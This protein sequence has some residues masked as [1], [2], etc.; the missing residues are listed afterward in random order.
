MNI[1]TQQDKAGLQEQEYMFPYHYIPQIRQDGVFSSIQF[2]D[3]GYDYLCCVKHIAQVIISLSPQSMLDVGCGDGRLIHE[4]Q[5][6]VERLVGI[7]FSERSL[8]FARGFN[9]H[10]EFLHVD[11]GA[12]SEEFELVT[13]IEV[14]EHIPDEGI[15]DFLK[16]L[17]SRVKKGGYLLLSVP[18][19]AFPLTPKHYRH[20]TLELLEEQVAKAQLPVVKV[21]AEYLFRACPLLKRLMRLTMNRFFSLEVR[22]LQKMIWHHVWNHL[23]VADEKS[24][25]HLLVCFRKNF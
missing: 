21:R 12:L 8:H 11:L 25:G 5:G 23:R 14:L 19:I 16:K 1:L 4:L 6:G 22:F 10:G 2:L 15:A 18:T 13:A 17:S 20:Y 24:G 7:D 9:A 3:W